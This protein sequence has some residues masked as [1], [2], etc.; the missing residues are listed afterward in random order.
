MTENKN[1]SNSK[2]VKIIHI[3]HDQKEK[4]DSIPDPDEDLFVEDITS[5][6]EDGI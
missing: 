1:N 2:N 6:R 5:T 3:P 4:K